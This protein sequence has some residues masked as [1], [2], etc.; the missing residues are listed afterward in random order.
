MVITATNGY[1]LKT[2]VSFL[3]GSCVSRMWTLSHQVD[4]K[5]RNTKLFFAPKAIH[6]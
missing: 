6:P 1:T 3:Y 4:I 5:P 2:V